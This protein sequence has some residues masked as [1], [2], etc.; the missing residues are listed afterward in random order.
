M[1]LI[2]HNLNKSDPFNFSFMFT[3]FSPRFCVFM[4]RFS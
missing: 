4:Q 3:F 2:S 1:P